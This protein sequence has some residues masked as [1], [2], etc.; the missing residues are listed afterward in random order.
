LFEKKP[1]GLL[2]FEGVAEKMEMIYELLMNPKGTCHSKKNIPYIVYRR[3]NW[4][5]VT[6]FCAPFV[7]QKT[8]RVRECGRA[9]IELPTGNEAFEYDTLLVRLGK[10][11]VLLMQESDFKEVFEV[12]RIEIRR[13]F[14]ICF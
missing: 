2:L 11:R 1:N 3:G 10:L 4:E 6:K 7:I 9:I 5:E 14:L 13:T 8:K 12:L